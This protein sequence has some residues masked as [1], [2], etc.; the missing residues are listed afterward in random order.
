M[1]LNVILIVLA[2]LTLSGCWSTRAY[3]Q[4]RPRVDQELPP[5]AE[6]QYPNRSTTRKVLVVE[7]IDQRQNRDEKAAAAA[8]SG[9]VASEPVGSKV[10]TETNDTV[11]VHEK[12]F[13]LPEVNSAGVTTPVPSATAQTYTV[14]KDDTL[15]K[16]AKKVYG[17]YSKWTKIYDAN[18]DVIKDPNF[19]KP[20]KVL[21]IPDLTAAETAQNQP[22]EK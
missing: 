1:R 8:S 2:S 12:N 5:G 14:Q 22:V 3:L 15:Q 13:T 4:D 17:S 9:K 10:V 11:V 21:T 19:L 16:I 7:V 20:G 6:A 18:R